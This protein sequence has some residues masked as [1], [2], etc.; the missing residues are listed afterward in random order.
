[1]L[2]RNDIHTVRLIVKNCAHKLATLAVR[3]GPPRQAFSGDYPM[4]LGESY[5]VRA[6]G[7]STGTLTV[8]VAQH[9]VTVRD[10]PN[11][12]LSVSTLRR[13]GGPLRPGERLR[14]APSVSIRERMH[15][16]DDDEDTVP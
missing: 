16:F 2:D 10:W 9:G 7:P 14:T 12:V 1:M 8:E 4:Q 11:S 3:L 15:P 5:E 13:V 6:W